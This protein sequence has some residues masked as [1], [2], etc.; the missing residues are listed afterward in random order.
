MTPAQTINRR[1]VLVAVVVALVTGTAAVSAA[2][3][4]A[5]GKGSGAGSTASAF[6]DADGQPILKPAAAHPST[7]SPERWVGPQGRT[8]QFVVT[9]LYSHSAPDDPIVHHGMPGMSHPHD[10]YG[11][12]EV[13]ADSTAASL[14][15]TQ[16]TCNKTVDTA[17]YWQPTLYDHGRALHPSEVAAYYRPAPGVAPTAVRTMPT[18][19]S[20]ITGNFEATTP[21]AGDATGWTCGS[22]GKLSDDPPTCHSSA[23]LHL[24]LTFPD[25]W[26]GRYLDS[27]DHHSHVDYSAGGRCPKGFP[28]HIPQIT[29]SFKFPV[30]GT[31][32]DLTLG[33]GNIYSAHGD[34]FNAWEPAGLKREI[35]H[36]IH[37]DA[38]CDLASN[39]EEEELFAA[40][41]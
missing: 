22:S 7:A 17:A 29:T 24:V 41:P 15:G 18:G 36:C 32:H 25:C 1:L 16:T 21:Q 27:V 33:S 5:P 19:L 8:G 13:D 4:G 10:F 34:F 35:D 40:N 11:A 2:L 14:V 12:T 9:C 3:R 30:Y 20:M 37:R 38:V 23:P 39:R 26:D 31:G 28:V 6:F